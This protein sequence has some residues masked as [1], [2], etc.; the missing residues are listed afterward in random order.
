ME[1]KDSEIDH[2]LFRGNTLLENEEMTH[3]QIVIKVNDCYMWLNLIN[4][5]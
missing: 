4:I 5:A 2:A 1:L 3:Q